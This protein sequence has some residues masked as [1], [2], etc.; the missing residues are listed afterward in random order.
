MTLRLCFSVDEERTANGWFA[1]RV[2]EFS[3]Y[4]TVAVVPEASGL[5]FLVVEE[6][7]GLDVVV[8][9]DPSL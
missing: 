8:F 6:T 9:V 3:L 4:D 5:L 1:G 2:D 7:I